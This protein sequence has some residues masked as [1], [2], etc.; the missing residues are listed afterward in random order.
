MQSATEHRE[1]AARCRRL[2]RSLSGQ[3]E[4]MITQLLSLAME[5]EAKALEVEAAGTKDPPAAPDLAPNVQR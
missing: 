2:A 5:H 3:N 4:P 1:Q